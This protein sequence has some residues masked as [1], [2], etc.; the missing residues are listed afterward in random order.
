MAGRVR[1]TQQGGQGLSLGGF[2]GHLGSLC[3]GLL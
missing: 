3:A 2:S 1:V